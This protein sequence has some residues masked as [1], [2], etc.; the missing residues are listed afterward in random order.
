M[1]VD[2]R[3]PLRHRLRV[4]AQLH[5]G[6]VERLAVGAAE[7]APMEHD[8]YRS[9]GGEIFSTVPKHVLSS[10]RL[11]GRDLAGEVAE[12]SQAIVQPCDQVMDLLGH[13]AIVG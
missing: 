11:G 7:P 10:P 6:E 9:S 1:Q 4:D 2:H 3:E 13:V 8:S 12:I 5:D